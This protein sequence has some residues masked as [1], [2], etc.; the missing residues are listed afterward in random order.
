M[1]ASASAP[2]PFI[3]RRVRLTLTGGGSYTGAI[4]ALDPTT[5]AIEIRDDRTTAI[6]TIR[7]DE[8]RD[9]QLLDQPSDSAPASSRAHAA[10][11]AAARAPV[12]PTVTTSAAVSTTAAQGSTAAQPTATQDAGTTGAAGKKKSRAERRKKKAAAA[13]AAAGEGGEPS[14]AYSGDDADAQPTNQQPKLAFD[15]DFDF[16]GALKTFDKARI[17]EEIR[18][19]DSTDPDTLL[20]SHNRAGGASTASDAP[21]M[22]LKR[23]PNGV[24]PSH[25]VKS[26]RLES[27]DEEG[28]QD[29][30]PRPSSRRVAGPSASSGSKAARKGRGVNL[31][32][33]LGIHEMVISDDEEED[34]AQPNASQALPNGNGQE[35]AAASDSGTAADGDTDAAVLPV[36]P[37]GGEGLLNSLMAS[38]AARMSGFASAARSAMGG[39]A[40]PTP[41]GSKDG[42]QGT[43]NHDAGEDEDDSIL[44]PPSPAVRTPSAAE[45]TKDLAATAASASQTQS[46][47]TVNDTAAVSRLQEE[48]ARLL[49][50]ISVLEAVGGVEV[51]ESSPEELASSSPGG[52]AAGSKRWTCTVRPTGPGEV[53]G[54]LRFGLA[55]TTAGAFKAGSA[56]GGSASGPTSSTPLPRLKTMRYLGALPAPELSA[57]DAREALPPKYSNPMGLSA[58]SAGVFVRRLRDGVYGP[59]R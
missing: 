3:G 15:E 17:W 51:R 58:D 32:A 22:V 54:H 16:E 47:N 40:P 27:G 33:K 23:G 4:T 8:V 50:R 10:A 20:V 9:M 45:P 55:T 37:A 19:A 57:T 56:A 39:S 31:Q 49:E 5:R 42:A 41:S 14:G 53:S 1:A 24:G 26:S 30:S 18:R 52:A 35:D 12:P 6:F 13:A 25:T 43:Q 38:A 7:G 21:V 59:G 11:S 28:T 46:S 44:I 34:D 29:G 48:I 36:S 2:S